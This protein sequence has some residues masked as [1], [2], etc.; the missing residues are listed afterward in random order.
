M[1]ITVINADNQIENIVV[2]ESIAAIE[3]AY[4]QSYTLREWEEGDEIYEEPVIPTLTRPQFYYMLAT[5][6][7]DDVV[8]GVQQYLK[9]NSHPLHPTVY[10]L[11]NGTSFNL[12]KTLALTNQVQPIVNALYPGADT[13]DQT[14]T[15]AWYDAAQWGG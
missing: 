9:E 15:A 1:K 3:S 5:I 10:G 12:I 7:L 6:N 13:S 8:A 4:P 2:A 14:I 11:L